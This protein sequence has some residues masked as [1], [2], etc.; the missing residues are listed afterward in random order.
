MSEVSKSTRL[1]KA[2]QEFNVGVPTIVEFLNKK[3]IKIDNNPN[4]KLDPEVYALLVKEYQ[5]EKMLKTSR[6]RLNL[7]TPSTKHL[8]C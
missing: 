8:N 1:G 4:T 7:N 2:A 5:S 3:G 6:K